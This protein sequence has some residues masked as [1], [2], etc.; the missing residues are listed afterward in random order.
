MVVNPKFNT[1]VKSCN[2]QK[3]CAQAID[4][5]Q[6]DQLSPA[7]YCLLK[8]F[9][10]DAIFGLLHKAFL[11]CRSIILHMTCFVLVTQPMPFVKH[12][13]KQHKAGVVQNTEEQV[14]DL[15]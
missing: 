9:K 4:Y 13:G 6:Q 15:K 14:F 12:T 5:T 11:L 3:I 10:I 1:L 7:W 2:A 8:M